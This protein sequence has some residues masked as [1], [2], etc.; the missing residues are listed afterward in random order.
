[1]STGWTIIFVLLLIFYGPIYLFI[2]L[3]ALGASI[4]PGTAST[5]TTLFAI[6][7]TTLLGLPFAG[8]GYMAYSK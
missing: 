6:F 4:A 2:V 5:Q 8:A 1:M 7:V 3:T